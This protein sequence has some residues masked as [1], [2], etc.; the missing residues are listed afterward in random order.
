MI[1][2]IP[3]SYLNEVCL[4]SL[5]ADDKK[6]NVALTQA[7]LDLEDVLGAEF[8]EEIED[9]YD[10]ETLS[11]DNDALYENYIK[12][13]LAWQS[14][15]HYLKFANLDATPTGIRE[16]N[17]ENST[18]ASDIKMYSLEKNVQMMAQRYKHRMINFLKLEQSKDSTK[19]S[20]WEDNC[21]EEMSFAI[22]AIDKGSDAL[23]Q[24]NKAI[25]TNE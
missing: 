7:Q 5:N 6:Y 20:L 15:L 4:L 9:Q 13:F 23:F 17:D 24:V 16:F 19:Y 12:D 14:Y 1:K 22:T 11:D 25:N 8:Y 2:L 21:R 3:Y 10:N 18:I